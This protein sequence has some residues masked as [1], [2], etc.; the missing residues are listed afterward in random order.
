MR[1]ASGALVVQKTARVP[2]AVCGVVEEGGFLAV[3]DAPTVTVRGPPVGRPVGRTTGGK[4]GR[5][6]VYA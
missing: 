6:G 3:C 1:S 4:V 2:V 5:V